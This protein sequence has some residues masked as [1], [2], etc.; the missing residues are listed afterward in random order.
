MAKTLVL[1][2][3]LPLA[4]CG[5]ADKGSMTKGAAIRV[6]HRALVA[7]DSTFRTQGAVAHKRDRYWDVEGIAKGS[8]YYKC[9]INAVNGKILVTVH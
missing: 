9:T 8:G 6:C 4:A 3:L 7:R 1:L 2:L 5:G